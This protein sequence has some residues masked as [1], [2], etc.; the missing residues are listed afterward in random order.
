M[1]SDLNSELQ[2]EHERWKEAIGLDDP[3][4]TSQALGIHEVLHA[5]FLIAEFFSDYGEGMAGI[6]PRDI[7]LLHSALSRQHVGF[8]NKDKWNQGIDIAATLFFGLIKDHPFHDANKRTALLCLIYH[9]MYIGFVPTCKQ[10][11]LEDFAVDVA[12]ERLSKYARFK[13]EAKK[14]NPDKEVLTVSWFLKKHT[15]RSD[16]T[17]YR[18]TYRELKKR[19]NAFGYDLRNPKGNTIDLIRTEER[20]RILGLWGEKKKIDVKVA[21]IGF[22]SWTKEVG[23]GAIKTV[24][25]KARL[26]LQEGVDS[27]TFFKAEDPIDCLLRRYQE[28]LISLANR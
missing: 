28:P 19:L 16:R 10:K 7:N 18:I 9:L 1:V 21:Q 20:P 5:H 25:E 11:H 4:R 23:R 3:Y 12:D 26:N 27:A 17:Y 8:G 2:R 13:D 14:K 6:G 22:P 15:R 24:R